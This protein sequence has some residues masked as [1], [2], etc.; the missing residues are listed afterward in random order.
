LILG[1]NVTLWGGAAVAAGEG[2]VVTGEGA[3]L[4]A[5]EM[6]QVMT[7][8]LNVWAQRSKDL[9]FKRPWWPPPGAGQG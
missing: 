3:A 6:Y 9:I 4:T 2:A 5:E 1:I 7:E 8:I